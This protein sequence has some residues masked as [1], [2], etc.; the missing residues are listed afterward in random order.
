M[1]GKC[2]EAYIPARF[3]S[4]AGLVP[5]RVIEVDPGGEKVTIQLTGNRGAYKR[6]EVLEARQCHVTPV[7]AIRSTKYG[8]IRLRY[9]KWIQ[10]GDAITCRIPDRNVSP[11]PTWD[12]RAA[13]HTAGLLENVEFYDNGDCPCGI[14]THHYHCAL[15]GGLIQTG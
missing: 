8:G 10:H 11:R 12:K 7:M 4:F 6:G 13:L 14:Q 15:C 9:A 2:N 5:C 3:D 1:S